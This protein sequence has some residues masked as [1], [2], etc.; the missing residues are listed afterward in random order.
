MAYGIGF[1]GLGSITNAHQD[2]YARCD[3]PVVAGYDPAQ[4]ACERFPGRQPR[5]RVYQRLEDLLD[6]PLV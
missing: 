1:V 4:Q 2:G 3:L 5:A 6:D